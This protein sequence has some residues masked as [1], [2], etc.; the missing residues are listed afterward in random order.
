MSCGVESACTKER[1]NPK[2][3]VFNA[4]QIAA[5]DDITNML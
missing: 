1:Q 5:G 2:E 3:S 4:L